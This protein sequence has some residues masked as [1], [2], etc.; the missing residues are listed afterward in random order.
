MLLLKQFDAH[1]CRHVQWHVVLDEALLIAWLLG[2]YLFND[3]FCLVFD[4]IVHIDKLILS[5]FIHW[6]C[7]NGGDKRDGSWIAAHLL[8]HIVVLHEFKLRRVSLLLEFLHHAQSDLILSFLIADVKFIIIQLRQKL[9][10]RIVV[11]CKHE[12]YYIFL[13]NSS[14]ST[15]KKL[16]RWYSRE[17]FYKEYVCN[18]LIW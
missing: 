4:A 11:I 12:V 1:F 6:V 13:L 16:Y 14:T 17:L 8:E 18:V 2:S 10:E 9:L 15:E 7:K 5:F 3:E